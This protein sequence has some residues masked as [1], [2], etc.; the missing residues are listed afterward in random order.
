M[1]RNQV[2]VHTNGEITQD[3]LSK[4]LKHERN[5]IISSHGTFLENIQVIKNNLRPLLNIKE[6]SQPIEVES[7]RFHQLLEEFDK[8]HQFIRENNETFLE[9]EAYFDEELI[10]M[11]LRAIQNDILLLTF[12]LLYSVVGSI[13]R[14][15][16]TVSFLFVLL[17]V[18]LPSF[19]LLLPS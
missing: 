10:S 15:Q 2:E 3:I 6:N 16:M 8:Y 9:A 12:P 7:L 19:V 13:T 5:D 17:L 11:L 18:F 1:K 14:N 4:R